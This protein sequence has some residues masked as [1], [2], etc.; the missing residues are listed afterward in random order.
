MELLGRERDGR[1]RV[2]FMKTAKNK[3]LFQN[4]SMKWKIQRF[5]N[6]IHLSP[7]AS[8]PST[9]I[10]VASQHHHY[11]RRYHPKCHALG[12]SWLDSP[13]PLPPPTFTPM[14][15]RERPSFA[16]LSPLSQTKLASPNYDC[17]HQTALLP[18]MPTLPP[19]IPSNPRQR[20]QRKARRRK[21]LACG[22]RGSRPEWNRYLCGTE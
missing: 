10:I 19:H 22:K 15:I 9:A 2:N 3:Y 21:L 16:M 7:S 11:Y 17:P 12:L 8:N 6:S 14:H 20:D 5:R 18:L 4:A 13:C 1:F